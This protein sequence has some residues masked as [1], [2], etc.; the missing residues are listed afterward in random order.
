MEWVK[1]GNDYQL[2]MSR[3]GSGFPHNVPDH[4]QLSADDALKFC[5]HDR[6]KVPGDFPSGVLDGEAYV[7]PESGQLLPGL[8]E[9]RSGTGDN[10][11]PGPG[12][13]GNRCTLRLDISGEDIHYDLPYEEP[14]TFRFFEYHGKVNFYY[15]GGALYR[16]GD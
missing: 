4:P 14:F 10:R 5:I 11:L 12:Y 1:Q 8:Y 15:C 13:V 2:A 3:A 7:G 16:I 6:K 9:Y